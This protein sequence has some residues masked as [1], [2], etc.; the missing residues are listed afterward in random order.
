MKTSFEIPGSDAKSYEIDQNFFTNSINIYEDGV[1]VY[2]E[3]NEKGKPF[4]VDKGEKKLFVKP[5]IMGTTGTIDGQKIQLQPKL[6]NVELIFV[7]LPLFNFILSVGIIPGLL[8]G[9][10]VA[11][12]VLIMRS[13]QSLGLRILFAVLVSIGV[14]FLLLIVYS[15]LFAS[16]LSNILSL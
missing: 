13:S 8:S 7:F 11:V 6:T 16:S 2:R 15:L 12:N 1:K 10:G 4:L 14:T 5:N 9:I 3:K